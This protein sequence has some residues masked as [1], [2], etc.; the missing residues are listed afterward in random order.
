MGAF[1]FGGCGQTKASTDRVSHESGVP[2]GVAD[3]DQMGNWQHVAGTPCELGHI[4]R[5]NGWEGQLTQH[6][7]VYTRKELP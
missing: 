5:S 6:G 7:W 4:V 3:A 2:R 1:G